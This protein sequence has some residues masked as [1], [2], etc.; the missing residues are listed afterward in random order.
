[1]KHN[2]REQP[3]GEAAE[4]FLS[5]LERETIDALQRSLGDP[6][7]TRAAIF[8]YANR[9]HEAGMP[10]RE[11]GALFGKC[12]VRAGFNEEDEGPAFDLLEFFSQI[13][14]PAQE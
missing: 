7:G 10:E 1:M 9:V 5:W 3:Q 11:I 8:L 6:E 4:R 13:A 2:F 12:V 14:G